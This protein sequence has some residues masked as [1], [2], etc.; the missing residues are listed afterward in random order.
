MDTMIL[1]GHCAIIIAVSLAG[2]KLSS[3]M[4]LTHTRTQ[5]LMSFI[6]GFIIGIAVHHLLPHGLSLISGKEALEKATAFVALGILTMILLLRTLHFHQHEFG[7][8]DHSHHHGHDHDHGAK[9]PIDGLFGIVLGLGLHAI[10]EGVT[11]GAS[12]QAGLAYGEGWLAGLGI[13]LAIL[14]HKPLDA[15]SIIG[16][17]RTSGYGP[18]ACTVTNISFALLCPIITALTFFGVEVLGPTGNAAPILGY[19]L[20][21]ASGAFLCIALSDLLPEIQFHGHDRVKLTAAL[22]LGSF[23]SYGLHFLEH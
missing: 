22:L 8:E 21:F 14:L 17:M 7:E 23:L 13:L 4:A 3:M 16:M 11:L 2:G 6:S 18:R 19:T 5:M 12:I 1:A 10:M 20:A 9:G 15:Y